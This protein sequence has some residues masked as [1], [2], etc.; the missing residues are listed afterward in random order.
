MINL[1]ACPDCG[2][3]VC[4]SALPASLIGQEHQE[5]ECEHCGAELV[6]DFVPGRPAIERA[7]RVGTYG[8]WS[9]SFNQTGGSA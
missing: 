2:N 8:S 9:A 7:W 6:R 1:D 5:V 3:I 4:P